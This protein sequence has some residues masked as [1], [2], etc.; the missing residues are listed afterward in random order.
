[1]RSPLSRG[2][3][4]H[5]QPVPSDAPTSAP[6][7]RAAE[8]SQVRAASRRRVLRGAAHGALLVALVAGTAAYAGAGP[9]GGATSSD[10]ASPSPAALALLPDA[11]PDDAV[12]PEAASRSEARSPLARTVF[13]TV[14]G[15]TQAL[16]TREETVE[17]VL[18]EAGVEIAT[19]DAVSHPLTS[20]VPAGTTV[21]VGRVTFVDGAERTEIPFETTET[22]DAT[23]PRGE[24]EVQ[25][26][27]VVGVQ[28][29]VYRAR[30]V[31]GVE[32]SR[33]EVM[34]T[35]VEPV[36]EVVQ[37]GTKAPTPTTTPRTVTSGSGT[38]VPGPV[39][40]GDPRSIGR[41]MV[42]ARGWG[43][44]QWVCLDRLFTRESN[45]N[46]YA[47]NR[48]S[49]AYGIPQALPGSKMGTVASDWRTN[50]ATQITWGLNYI[51]GRYG[52]PC[53]AWAHSQSV[54]WY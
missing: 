33:E 51:A 39:Y 1:M 35:V 24:R 42:A 23:R 52:T 22:Q 16:T 8:R 54:G 3:D 28:T 29:V 45:W 25:T 21:V 5:V 6:R 26:A 43:E 14:D 46:P 41:S 31:D 34:R 17:D 9:S 27:G 11:L 38:W 36:A 53:G 2:S 20:F 13:I 47:E 32:V 12:L 44:D 19:E 10:V 37:V 50:P 40:A 15:V 18:D 30:L 49:G 4:R 7:S 48:S